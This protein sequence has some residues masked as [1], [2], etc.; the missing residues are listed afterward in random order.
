MPFFRFV[1]PV[2]LLVSLCACIRKPA[3]APAIGEAFVAPLTLKLRQ[4]ISPR[5]EEVAQLRHGEKVEIL[6]IRRRFVKVR[7]SRGAEGWTDNRQ[8][9]NARQMEELK[10]LQRLGRELPSQGKG[11]VHEALNIHT[12]PNRQAPSFSQIPERGHVEVLGRGLFPRTPY[13]APP[14]LPPAPPPVKK[15]TKEAK[16]DSARIP[17]P[18]RP[19]PPPPPADWL[20]ISRREKR[21]GENEAKTPSSS[22]GTSQPV[23]YD[24]W[25]LVR[26][27]D[28][29]VGWALGR[30]IIMAIPDDVAQY[31]EGHR[32]TS[33]FALA[34]LKDENGETRHHWLWTTLAPGA[35]SCDFDG[36]RVFVFNARRSRY[37]TAYRE[38]NLCGYHPVQLTSVA[39]TEGR[40]TFAVPG[41]TLIVEDG[42]GQVWK[43]T[44]AYQG[45]RVRMVSKEPWKRPAPLAPKLATSATPAA[46]PPPVEPSLLDRVR[47]SVKKLFRR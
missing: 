9:L 44:Y 18:P 2:A 6:Q 5:S 27:P 11:T 32:I 34:D 16:K 46:A 17:P 45:Y 3:P 30:M 38:R 25:Y 12:E 14:L 20:E 35:E 42:D 36:F 26:A 21:A 7:T 19:S 8:L 37:E 24:E 22:P 23:R 31:S 28:G 33:Y 41:F 39:V 15:A 43:R 40:K 47:D 13:V 4:D 1:A 10:E 29:S